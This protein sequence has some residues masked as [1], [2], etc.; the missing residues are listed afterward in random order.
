MNRIASLLAIAVAALALLA[1]G[2]ATPHADAKPQTKQQRCITKGKTVQRSGAYRLY[3]VETES[4]GV[5]GEAGGGLTVYDLRSGK[6]IGDAAV[7]ANDGF[8]DSL[9]ADPVRLQKDGSV[10]WVGSAKG[11][12]DGPVVEVRAMKRGKDKTLDSGLGINPKSLK[13]TGSTIS[14]TKGGAPASAAF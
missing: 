6:R 8:S 4:Y 5:D 1:A 13:V 14:W 3:V 11:D 9:S 12:S 7:V 10:A 2:P